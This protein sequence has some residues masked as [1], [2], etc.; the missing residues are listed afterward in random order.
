MYLVS[1][2]LQIIL[3]SL[4]VSSSGHAQ[5]AG[6]FLPDYIDR[7]ASGATVVVLLAYFS[8]E[9][10]FVIHDFFIHPRKI[11][12]W[13]LLIAMSTSVT[14]FFYTLLKLIATAF[15]LWL[16]FLITMLSLFS[17]AWCKK[18]TLR[19]MT[20]AP[21]FL[22]GVVQGF[23]CLPAVSRLGTT[24][25]AAC[26]LGFSPAVAF[27]IS[28]ALQLPL[29]A[30]GF[31]EGFVTVWRNGMLALFDWW[32]LFPILFAMVVA[33]LILWA[34]EFLMRSQKLWYLGFYMLLPTMLALIFKL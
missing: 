13:L 20:Y 26:W 27:R 8:K 21:I 9:I 6:M 28:C 12:S 25:T 15:P 29:F 2:V 4:P 33:Y 31:L 32:Q 11:I 23:A 34:V 17:L 7:L 5:L 18:V 10:L 30:V 19:S 14:V 1:V 24:Y 22:L 16:G 3:E